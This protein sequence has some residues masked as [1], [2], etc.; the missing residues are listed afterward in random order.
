MGG[1]EDEDE[2]VGRGGRMVERGE[3]SGEEGGRG[4]VEWVENG[5]PMGVGGDE[6]GSRGREAD[7]FG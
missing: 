6:G 5:G 7:F 2:E 3:G 1:A 4:G